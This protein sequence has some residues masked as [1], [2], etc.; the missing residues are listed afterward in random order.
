[1][2]EYK[3]KV[4]HLSSRVD[5][6][7]L[8]S[9]FS[10]SGEIAGI[11][12]RNNKA[13]IVSFFFWAELTR[14]SKQQR[15]LMRLCSSL[16]SLVISDMLEGK[17]IKVT[18]RGFD[19]RAHS[20][21]SDIGG[22]ERDRDRGRER[23]RD[24]GRESDRDREYDRPRDRADDRYHNRDRDRDRDRDRGR[25]RYDDYRPARRDR[26]TNIDDITCFICHEKG[27]KFDN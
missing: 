25:D 20:E 12:L 4:S 19:D 9:L 6:P 18:I 8:K 2:K 21:E 15:P 1:M 14:N 10:K 3:I 13:T 16:T 7:L 27:H 17:Q 24:R 23:D 22:R 5:E 11:T 26:E